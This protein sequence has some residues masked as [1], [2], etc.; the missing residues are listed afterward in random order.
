MAH[1]IFKPKSKK[2]AAGYVFIILLISIFT[3]GIVYVTMAHPFQMIYQTFYDNMSS[4]FQPTMQK[5][6]S[7]WIMFPMIVI[8]G[9]I[10]WAFIN[11]LKRE[12][13]SGMF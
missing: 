12:P 13:D 2:A 10:V 4:D 6:R 11:S 7:V 3:I 5:I 1:E 8:F 9:L